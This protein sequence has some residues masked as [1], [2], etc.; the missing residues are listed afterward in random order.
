MLRFANKKIE[1]RHGKCR[2]FSMWEEVRVGRK[3]GI[4]PVQF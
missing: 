3:E 1:A 2:V 4:V